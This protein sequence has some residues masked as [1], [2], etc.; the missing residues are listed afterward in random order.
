M[1]LDSGYSSLPRSCHST[2][3]DGVS[4]YGEPPGSPYC[5]DN[6]LP[7]LETVTEDQEILP[8]RNN[9]MFKYSSRKKSFYFL[10]FQFQVFLK[11]RHHLFAQQFLCNIALAEIWF[12]KKKKKKNQDICFLDYF[13]FVFACKKALFYEN[14]LKTVDVLLSMRINFYVCNKSK[15]KLIF[16]F[17]KIMN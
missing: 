4:E 3:L 15:K 9:G 5:I 10:T 17:F 14:T 13:S 6:M 7:L 2:G 8:R 1:F 16:F 12:K 11:S